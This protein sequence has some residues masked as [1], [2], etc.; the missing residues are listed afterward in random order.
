MA[1]RADKIEMH[2]GA[3]QRAADE[4]RSRHCD[5]ADDVS[6]FKRVFKRL[7]VFDREAPR[8][9]GG[10]RRSRLARIATPEED[11][12]QAPNAGVRLHHMS[13]QS[14][15]AYDEESVRVPPGQ[16]VGGERGSGGGTPGGEHR[17]V[18]QSNRVADLV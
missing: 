5:S 18:E 14:T 8:H 15:G 4:R 2:A 1:E 12:A 10:R 11:P 16:L 9:A 17:P 6:L 3:E 7:S 13:D